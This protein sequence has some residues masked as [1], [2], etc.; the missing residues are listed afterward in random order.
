MSSMHHPTCLGET[1]RQESLWIDCLSHLFTS[2]PSSY[3]LQEEL[4]LQ[5]LSYYNLLKKLIH[6]AKHPQVLGCM[7]Q[8]SEKLCFVFGGSGAGALSRLQSTL[9]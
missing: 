5:I 7:Q 6:A 1:V 8:E 2:S 3:R 9:L 4:G